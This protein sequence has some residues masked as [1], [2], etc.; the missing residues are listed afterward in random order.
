VKA[1]DGKSEMNAIVRFMTHRPDT[2]F[3]WLFEKAR[4]SLVIAP[5]LSKRKA[6]YTSTLFAAETRRNIEI[7]PRNRHILNK[8]CNG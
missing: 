6:M 1:S 7:L 2:A 3:F 8:L 4:S 5:S